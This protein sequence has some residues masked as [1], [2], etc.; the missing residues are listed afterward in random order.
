MDRSGSMSNLTEKSVEG[1]NQFVKDQKKIEG[2]ADL[3]LVIFDTEYETVFEDVDIQNVNPISANDIYARGMTALLDGVGRTVDSVGVKLDKLGENEKPEHVIFV[4]MT[5]G[6]ENASVEYKR[7]QIK[8]LIEQQQNTYNWT[9]L[10]LGANQDA[11]AEASSLGISGFTTANYDA[12]GVG[13]QNAYH[14][15]STF[16]SNIRSNVANV[17]LQD[18]YTEEEKDIE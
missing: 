10:F 17:S 7:E 18:T 16:A 13:T 3:T 6:H 11:F 8:N 14:T 2:T 5:D 4:I 1:F 12:S 15:T 9:F